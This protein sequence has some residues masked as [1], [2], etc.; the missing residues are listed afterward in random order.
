MNERGA[1]LQNKNKNGK[2]EVSDDREGWRG[3]SSAVSAAA[4][5]RACGGRETLLEA[6]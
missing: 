1:Q 3:K 4:L 6:K 5:I 2:Q